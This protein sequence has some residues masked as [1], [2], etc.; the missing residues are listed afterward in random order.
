MIWNNCKKIYDN[1]E[2]IEEC[3]P[4]TKMFQDYVSYSNQI[5]HQPNFPIWYDLEENLCFGL[6]Q[7]W[8]NSISRNSYFISESNLFLSG[9]RWDKGFVLKYFGEIF[10]SDVVENDE[11]IYLN[12]PQLNDIQGSKVLIVGGGPTTNSDKWDPK[13]YDH[14]FSCNHFF[15]NDRIGASR[16]TLATVT[17]EVDLSEDNI[18]FHEYMKNS[19]TIICFEDRFT[20]EQQ[21]GLRLM[22][23]KYPGRVMYAHT[24]YRG[25]IGSTPR[26]MCMAA[27]MGAKEIDVVGMDGFKRGTK[28]G[29]D[30]EHSFET[31][32]VWQGT[33]D[34]RLYN[35]HYVALWDYLLNHIGKDIKFRNLGEGHESNMTTNISRQMFPLK[36]T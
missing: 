29:Q 11:I 34:Y 23:E 3:V 7:T 33:H 12:L 5:G 8:S 30:N 14:I 1:E 19:E 22:H 2:F 6:D 10:G 28:L 24:R 32:K 18:K 21:Q 26:L 4:G 20:P 25:K 35:R 9:N 15:L 27:L 17:T 36:N 31:G 13:D 16:P